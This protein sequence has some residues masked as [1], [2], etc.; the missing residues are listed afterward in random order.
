[1]QYIQQLDQSAIAVML[2]AL[3][4]AAIWLAYYK[5]NKATRLEHQLATSKVGSLAVGTV[6][7]RGKTRSI[8]T[9][10]T[11]WGQTECIA[12]HYDKQRVTFKDGRLRRVSLE[13]KT[14]ALPFELYDETGSVR[15]KVAD[16]EMSGLRIDYH[17][18]G[19]TDIVHKE[20]VLTDDVDALM[21]ARAEPD[22]GQLVLCKDESLGVFSLNSW[23]NIKLERRRA[24]MY[25]ILGAYTLITIVLL[26]IVIGA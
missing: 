21:I 2:F 23:E 24:P 13:Q 8:E 20:V 4:I 22:G 11:P 18:Q 19:G 16:L 3:V 25:R 17:E 1:M 26:A 15:V 10:F 12:Y 14:S 7:V 5:G 9:T 6:E